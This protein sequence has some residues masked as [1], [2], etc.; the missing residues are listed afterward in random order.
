MFDEPA[1]SKASQSDFGIK[2]FFWAEFIVS[3]E[4]ERGVDIVAEH[5]VVQPVPEIYT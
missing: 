3:A 5:L 4:F 2:I 1:D